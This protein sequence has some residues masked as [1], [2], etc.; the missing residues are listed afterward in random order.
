MTLLLNTIM[1]SR[2]PEEACEARRLEG[3]GALMQDQIE[4]STLD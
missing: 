3:H 4:A 2:H 1:G